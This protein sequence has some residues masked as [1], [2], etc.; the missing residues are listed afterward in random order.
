MRVVAWFCEASLTPAWPQYSGIPYPARPLASS[1]A[2]TPG[3][4]VTISGEGCIQE[5]KPTHWLP[6]QTLLISWTVGGIPLGRVAS[7]KPEGHPLR[8]S[9]MEGD[10]EQ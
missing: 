4:V 9:R 5:R 10:D 7:E 6:L 8:I 2:P 1:P 3:T